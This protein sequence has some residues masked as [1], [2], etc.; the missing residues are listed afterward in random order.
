MKLLAAAPG[1]CLPLPNYV[2]VIANATSR[3]RLAITPDVTTCGIWLFPA[4]TFGSA[5]EALGIEPGQHESLCDH[6]MAEIADMQ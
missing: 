4:C 5:R 1:R 6:S 3:R 2:R